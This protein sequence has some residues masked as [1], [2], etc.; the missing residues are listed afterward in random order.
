[1]PARTEHG[2]ALADFTGGAAPVTD[3][4]AAPSPAPPPEI[5]D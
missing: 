2:R 3:A 4:T 5:F 1:H